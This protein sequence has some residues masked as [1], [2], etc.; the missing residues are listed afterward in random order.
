MKWQAG[1]RTRYSQCT[2]FQFSAGLKTWKMTFGGWLVGWM[3]VYVVK[4]NFTFRGFVA[5]VVKRA[6]LILGLVHS[7]QTSQPFTILTRKSDKLRKIIDIRTHIF[8]VCY[9]FSSLKRITFFLLFFLCLLHYNRSSYSGKRH[10]V[11]ARQ[12][13]STLVLFHLWV[14]P[15]TPFIKVISALQTIDNP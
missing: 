3:Q 9:S 12:Y 14:V 5:R 6:I 1:T 13:G 10:A 15:L 2:I 7:T 4:K 8:L 11:N